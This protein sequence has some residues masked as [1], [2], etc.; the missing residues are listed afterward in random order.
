MIGLEHYL[1]IGA[2]VFGIGLFVA[3][4]K[5]NAVAVLM[6]VELML[7]AVA[8]TFLAFSRFLPFGAEPTPSA[9][10]PI[11]GH[12]FVV[13]LLTVAAAEA[14]VAMGLAVAIYR[15][16]RTIDVEKIDVMRW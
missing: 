13:F 12:V 7:N 9:P 11:A 10:G 8:L 15:Q 4:A 16:R 14:A 2:I 3:L 6:G 5:R 1:V